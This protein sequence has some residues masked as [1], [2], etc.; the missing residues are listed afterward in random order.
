M[1]VVNVDQLVRLQRKPEDIRNV[2]APPSHSDVRF[3]TNFNQICILAHVVSK[4]LQVTKYHQAIFLKYSQFS[5]CLLG[6]WKD[7]VDR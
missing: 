2:R 4:G 5:F 3:Y 6:S 1:P 7:I